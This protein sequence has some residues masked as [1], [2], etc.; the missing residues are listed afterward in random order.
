[1]VERLQ[2]LERRLGAIQV[3]GA[4]AVLQILQSLLQQSRVA[5]LENVL[6]ETRR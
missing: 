1:L 6:T 4:K 3:A 2:N 5:G